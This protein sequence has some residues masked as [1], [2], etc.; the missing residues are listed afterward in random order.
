MIKI[1]TNP[2]KNFVEEVRAKIKENNGHCACAIVF[3]ESTKCMCE[4]FR[5]QIDRGEEG[6]CGCGLYKLTITKD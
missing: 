4:E 1:T 2:D 3:D 6:Y 5:N